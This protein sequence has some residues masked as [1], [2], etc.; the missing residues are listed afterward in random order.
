MCTP[1]VNAREGEPMAAKPVQAP[2]TPYHLAR[3]TVLLNREYGKSGHPADP[4]RNFTVCFRTTSHAHQEREL[5]QAF[6]EAEQ[7]GYERG[8]ADR[9]ERCLQSDIQRIRERLAEERGVAKGRE[10]ERASIIAYGERGFRVSVD[11]LD[12]IRNGAHLPKPGDKEV[13]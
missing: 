6:A 11:V 12:G 9:D 2:V 4:G 10:L 8:L 1:S 5:A 13:E 7:R 3:A